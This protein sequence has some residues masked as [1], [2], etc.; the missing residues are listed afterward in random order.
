MGSWHLFPIQPHLISAIRLKNHILWFGFV[1]ARFARRSEMR[2]CKI[3]WM[4]AAVHQITRDAL[5]F[6][7]S[8]CKMEEAAVESNAAFENTAAVLR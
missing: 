3:D 2:G 8:L 5:M 6:Q 4:Q 7:M 1:L